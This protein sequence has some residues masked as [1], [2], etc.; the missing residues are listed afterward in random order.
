MKK[1]KPTKTIKDV[2][3]PFGNYMLKKM[4][5]RDGKSYEYVSKHIIKE[6]K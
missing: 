1:T 5:K 6:S 3:P 4:C 2:L